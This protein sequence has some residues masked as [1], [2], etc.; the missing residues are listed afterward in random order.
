MLESGQVLSI[1]TSLILCG[2]SIMICLPRSRARSLV[3]EIGVQNLGRMFIAIEA[4]N[5]VT[6]GHE[7]E[8]E[9]EDWR[10][11]GEVKISAFSR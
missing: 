2:R 4:T 6:N 9:V 10:Q 3:G 7:K 5:V 8:S 1:D 11:L